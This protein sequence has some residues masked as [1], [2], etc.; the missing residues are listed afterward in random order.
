MSGMNSKIYDYCIVGQGIA[1]TLMAWHLLKA[2]KNVC[3]IDNFHQGASSALAAGIVNP[4]T[5]R[6]YVR[7]WRI[8]EL[9]P[10]AEEVY[11]EMSREL[12]AHI[13]T[14]INLLRCLYT[15]ED[16]NNW[17]A[18]TRDE[19]VA[20]FML[21]LADA[22]EFKGKVNE[23]L[24]YGELT[25]TF[26]VHMKAI[27]C[28][29]KEIWKSEGRYIEEKFD[30]SHLSLHEGSM[31]YHQMAFNSI[32]FC[33]GHQ[34]VFNPFFSDI[35][36]RPSKGEVVFVQIPGQPFKKMYKDGVFIV[37]H[38]DDIYWIGGGYENNPQDDIPTEK[39]YMKLQE[40][41]KRILKIEYRILDHK[42][43]IRP[44]M[45]RRRPVILKHTLWP[46]M[47]LFNG[48][49]TKGASLGPFFSR[50]LT[51]YLLYKNP[52]DLIIE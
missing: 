49:G 42:A 41:L 21:P 18:R 7:S 22:S 34:G 11:S 4:I 19:T 14:K 52:Q 43:A 3:I 25:G 39:A 8:H 26:Q 5:G 47:Y 45:S 44:T 31:R 15:V 12:N 37:H 20:H 33:E 51:Q 50:Q 24:A 35:G 6:N 28:G 48:L 36:M 23:P 38:K 9:L 46:E 13:Y 40:E 29:F 17:L 30:Y 1:G 10:I 27:I 16:E 32:I 2:G